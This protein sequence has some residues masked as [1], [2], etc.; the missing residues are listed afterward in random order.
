[1]LKYTLA[2]LVALAPAA[3]KAEDGDRYLNLA[4]CMAYAT[5]KADLDGKKAVPPEYSIAIATVGKEYMMEASFLGFD[6]N[7]AQTV[8]VNELMRMNRIK[9]EKGIGAVKAEVGD[10][11]SRIATELT[12]KPDD[13]TAG[14]QAAPQHSK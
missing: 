5:V 14:K 12:P 9:T 7:M 1:M 10:M 3:V 13:P 8:V 2:A 11:C 4:K 6:D